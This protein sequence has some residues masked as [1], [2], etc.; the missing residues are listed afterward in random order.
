MNLRNDHQRTN[1]L[2]ESFTAGTRPEPS[3]KPICVDAAPAGFRRVHKNEVVSRGDYVLN[4]LQGIE[5]WEGP[6]GFRADSF[7]K[8]IYRRVTK[9]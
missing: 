9:V 3:L 2:N 1:A 5:P 6:G 7:V 8:Q 4:D